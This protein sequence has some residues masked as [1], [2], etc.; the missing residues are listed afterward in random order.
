MCSTVNS[1]LTHTP[2]DRP[3]AL[4]YKGVWDSVELSRVISHMSPCHFAVPVMAVLLVCLSCRVERSCKFV[5]I[6][7]SR[8]SLVP[9]SYGVH[10]VA[11]LMC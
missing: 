11:V 2:R 6:L 3:R 7:P 10:A 8:G 5:Q 1:L 4:G 9:K